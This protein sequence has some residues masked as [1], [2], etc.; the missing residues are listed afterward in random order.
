[1]QL[2]KKKNASCVLLP[3][4]CGELITFTWWSSLKK[5][6]LS[7]NIIS[8]RGFAKLDRLLREKTN[9]TTL[10]LEGTILFSN[11]KTAWWLRKKSTE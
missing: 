5:Q 2:S 11:K 6:N 1:M 7:P 8:E 9:A 3:C 4:S 10:A